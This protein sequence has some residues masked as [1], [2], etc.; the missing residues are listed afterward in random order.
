[1]LIESG[2]EMENYSTGIVSFPDAEHRPQA[3]VANSTP[4]GVTQSTSDP[5]STTAADSEQ[6][7]YEL[8]TPNG[9]HAGLLAGL[10]ADQSQD[11]TTGI[12]VSSRGVVGKGVQCPVLVGIRGCRRAKQRSMVSRVRT[13]VRHRRTARLLLIR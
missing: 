6:P 8:T 11:Y 5:A 7:V 1:M 3:E 2:S 10:M 4:E 9:V 13:E 12:G